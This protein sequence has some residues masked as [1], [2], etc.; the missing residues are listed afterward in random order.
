MSNKSISYLI[1]FLV[2]SISFL[3]FEVNAGINKKDFKSKT[4]IE[5]IDVLKDDEL[6]EKKII[7]RID[8]KFMCKYYLATLFD[9][10]RSSKESLA[11]SSQA[12]TGYSPELQREAMGQSIKVYEQMTIN[13][14]KTIEKYCP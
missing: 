11:T 14:L 10:V 4:A 6:L 13:Q 7:Q 5:L 9:S 2:T 3:N 8:K 1:G 12:L